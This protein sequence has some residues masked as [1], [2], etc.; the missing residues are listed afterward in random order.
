MQPRSPRVHV[1][2]LGSIGS[3]VAHSLAEVPYPLTPSVTLLLHRSS[4]V[5]Q[6]FKN[7]SRI[8]LETRDGEMVEHSNF[9]LE[10]LQDSK[11]HGVSSTSEPEGMAS[12]VREEIIDH[13]VVSVKGAQTVAA[14]QPLKH[15]LDASSYILFLQNGSGMMEEVSEKIFPD[16]Q[17]RPSYI[18][19]VI[20]HGVTQNSPFNITHTGF[21]ATSLGRVPRSETAPS[22]GEKGAASSYLLEALPLVP[23]FNATGYSF[24]DVF[25]M[26]LE[27]L[28]VNA[29][30]NPLCA[31]NNAKNK[32]LFTIPEI[33]KAL[34]T[35]ISTVIQALP[36]LQGLEGVTSRFAVEKLES[37]VNAILTKTAE[38]TCSMVVDLRQG[39]KTEIKFINGYW[40]RRGREVGIPTPINDNLVRQVLERQGDS[41]LAKEYL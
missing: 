28:S 5:D 35:E 40:C 32:F 38:T 27:K 33:R 2:G 23:R 12:T 29:F 10:F 18:T 37:T 14:I 25:Q 9:N 17:T 6:Y 21:A 19:G 34:L 3:F 15:R 24:L 20:S 22:N 16:P 31:L 39:R 26:Q 41:E 4:L 30:C 11:W 36:E 7:G 8:T 13:L 1:L